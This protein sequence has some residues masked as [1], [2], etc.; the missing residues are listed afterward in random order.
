MTPEHQAQFWI[1][2]VVAAFSFLPFFVALALLVGYALWSAVLFFT[3]MG[4][5]PF[6]EDNRRPRSPYVL[7]QKKRDAVL[8]QSFNASKVGSSWCPP[9]CA[10]YSSLF[11]SW[12][13]CYF[14]LRIHQNIKYIER[15]TFVLS[16]DVN[17]HVWTLFI[18][19]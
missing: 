15:G 2:V 8:K 14:P 6:A 11:W 17:T 13:A 5:N 19:T 1:A 18:V 9:K 16:D 10:L 3:Q 4:P 12:K 7:D